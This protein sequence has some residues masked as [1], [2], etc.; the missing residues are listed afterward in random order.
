M[1]RSAW[2]VSELAG[3]MARATAFPRALRS[4]R[5]AAFEPMGGG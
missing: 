5:A 2:T 4:D 3:R 1:I